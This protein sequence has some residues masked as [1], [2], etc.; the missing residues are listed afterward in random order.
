MASR[1]LDKLVKSFISGSSNPAGSFD[2][3]ADL[4]DPTYLTFKIDFFPD[5]GLSIPDDAYS[6][7]GLF[8]KMIQQDITNYGF[9]DSAA[10]YLARIGSP[11]R[12]HYLE[13]FANLLYQIQEE[14]PWYFQSI[15]GLGD[16]YKIDPANN[17]RGKDKVLTIECL[18]SI[19]LRMSLLADAYRNLAFEVQGM[20]EVLPIN[21]RTFNMHIHVLEF[22]RFNTTFGVIADE[23]AKTGRTVQGQANQQAALDAKRRN[24][25][26]QPSLFTGTFDNLNGVL[27]NINND[28]GGL[29]SYQPYGQGAVDTT[30]KS[31]FEAISVQTFVLKDCEFDFFS[32][33]PGYLDNVSVKEIPEATHRFKI[34]VGKIQKTSTYSFDKYVISEWAKYS[35]IDPNTIK[36]TK[37]GRTF[38]SSDNYFD[39]IDWKAETSTEFWGSY[40]EGI[41]PTNG[42][43][44]RASAEAYST[45]AKESEFLRKKPLERLIGGLLNNAVGAVNSEINSVLGDA[46]GGFLGRS[47]RPY[48]F[49]NVYGNVSSAARALNGFLDPTRQLRLQGTEA[50]PG[51]VL[52]NIKFEAL[53]LDTTLPKTSIFGQ[54]NIS[55]PVLNTKNI[56]EG[57]LA[58]DA[59]ASVDTNPPKENIFSGMV[60]MGEPDALGKQNIFSQQAFIRTEGINKENIYYQTP[61]PPTGNVGNVNVF[62]TAEMINNRPNDEL[63]KDNVFGEGSNTTNQ[64]K[65]SDGLGNRNVFE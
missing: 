57:N 4:Q 63:G 10:E 15:T 32:E 2:P 30:V 12:Q 43:F 27:N 24:V 9:Y 61:V 50:Q 1:H 48:P 64:F 19:D 44:D 20:R 58:R 11:A 34:N 35:R 13:I 25:F 65:A 56:Y 5:L 14:A 38:T 51:D 40:R 23:L 53:N 22:R 26:P 54:Q 46:T 52:R 18:E 47:N 45:S 39:E 41:F 8:R 33:S 37:L 16:L 59:S 28:L 31:A 29:F 49:G 55:D 36:T 42:D 3:F 62:N 60:N 6:S 17:F 21:L 7:G